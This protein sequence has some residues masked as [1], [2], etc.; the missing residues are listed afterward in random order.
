MWNFIEKQLLG[1][2]WLKQAVFHLIS[3]TG[4]DMESRVADSLVFFIYDVI[5]IFILLSVLIFAVSAGAHEEDPRTLQR[6]QCE[7]D[8]CF[9]GNSN[10]VLFLFVDSDFYW[11]CQRKSSGGCVLVFLDF[12]ANGGSGSLPALAQHIWHVCR[13][14]CRLSGGGFGR[15][16]RYLSHIFS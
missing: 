10:T 7:P 3:L 5:K 6:H 2:Q 16:F 9:A 15:D 4:M 12:L 13:D 8:G 1:M 11:F 14:I